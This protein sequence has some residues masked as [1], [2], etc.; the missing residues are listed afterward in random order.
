MPSTIIYHHFSK[1]KQYHKPLFPSFSLKK[2]ELRE[3]D[4]KSTENLNDFNSFQ[5]KWLK[6]RR[7]TR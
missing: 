2:I 5:Q 6:K 3:D 4:P 1:F 7:N